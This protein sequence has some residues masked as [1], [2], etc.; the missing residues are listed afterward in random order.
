M[1]F[2]LEKKREDAPAILTAD[3]TIVTYGELR[4]QAEQFGTRIRL[5]GTHQSTG[6]RCLI[7]CICRNVPGGR[8]ALEDGQGRE[9]DSSHTVGELVYYGA[10]VSLGYAQSKLDLQCADERKGRLLTGDMA[11]RDSEGYYYI[12]G[13]KNGSSKY[14]ESV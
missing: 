11:M 12:I 7:F 8:F 5:C 14:L 4:N 2:S 13:R 9:I 10:N 1:I 3:G 6:M